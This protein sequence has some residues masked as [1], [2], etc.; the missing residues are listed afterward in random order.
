MPN[1]DDLKN[2]R[3][4]IKTT[5]F[6]CAVLFLLPDNLKI[7]KAH[8]FKKNIQTL[9]FL[10]F[11]VSYYPYP[12]LPSSPPN[13][14]SWM[15]LVP[16][17]LRLLL[18]SAARAAGPDPCFARSP[19]VVVERCSSRHRRKEHNRL[20]LAGAGPPG[21]K[22]NEKGDIF[23]HPTKRKGVGTSKSENKVGQSTEGY[24][25][26]EVESKRLA[27]IIWE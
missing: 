2:I 13:L 21:L 14:R 27:T 26:E 7:S 17:Q 4:L 10:F 24:I 16:T 5:H 22:T 8:N 1:F 6:F 15:L 11:C 25:C 20:L 9:I 19:P 3:Y 23:P 18:L 12:P